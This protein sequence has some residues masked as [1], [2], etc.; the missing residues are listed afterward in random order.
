[1]QV[2]NMGDLANS[3]RNVRIVH[4][5]IPRRISIATGLFIVFLLFFYFFV[6][7]LFF[8]SNEA[9][10]RLARAKRPRQ[11]KPLKQASLK[12]PKFRRL[13]V[14]KGTTFTQSNAK[15]SLPKLRIIHSMKKKKIWFLFLN[16]FIE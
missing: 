13:K 9:P 5:V 14:Q 8:K 3:A 1:M 16:I 6:L 11:P 7:I 4:T 2:E 12:S 10:R 15:S